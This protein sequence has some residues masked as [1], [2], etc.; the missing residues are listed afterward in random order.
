MAIGS[1]KLMY[2]RCELINCS[3]NYADGEF[4]S[5]EKNIMIIADDGYYFPL[6]NYYIDDAEASKWFVTG[7]GKSIEWVLGV[8]DINYYFSLGI[9]YEA[10]PDESSGQSEIFS[11]FANLYLTNN[12]ELAEVS[13]KRFVVGGES[14]IDYGQYISSLYVLPFE[15]PSEIIEDE[16]KTI[17]LGNLDTT[18]STTLLNSYYF[19]VDGG[20][21]TIPNKY[22]NLY[23][24]VNTECIL[25]LPFLDNV[26]INAEYVIGQVLTIN[27][28]IELYSGNMTINVVSSFN[29]EIVVS[30]QG[31]IGMNIPYIQKNVGSAANSISNV[32]KNMINRC[33]IEVNRNVPYTKNNNI[34]G[35]SVVEYGKIGDYNGYLECDSLVLN[36]Q[37][38]N[39][40]QDVIKNILNKGVFI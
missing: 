36:T 17:I 16:E 38:T 34:F 22:E 20:V 31:L 39:Q 19:N 8:R 15:I 29:N 40:E 37:A 26:Y 11:S 23:D 24:Y 7:S 3:C 13:L 30:V 12:N 14:P 10:I 35:G 33:F 4:L 5:D 2:Y 6:D 1:G 21:I 28:I 18:V 27:F 25:H 32:Y 9:R